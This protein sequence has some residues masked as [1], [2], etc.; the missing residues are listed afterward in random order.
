MS[1]EMPKSLGLLPSSPAIQETRT[2]IQQVSPSPVDLLKLHAC[3]VEGFCHGAHLPAG[4]L[5]NLGFKAGR[6]FWFQKVGE[7][8]A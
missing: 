3:K 7:W 5:F 8:L 1:L 2:S 4:F 6:M